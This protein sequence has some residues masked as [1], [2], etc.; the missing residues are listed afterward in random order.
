M[1]GELIFNQYQ[2]FS[3]HNK[4]IS[5]MGGSILSGKNA[6]NL[7]YLQQTCPILIL[8]TLTLILIS[9]QFEDSASDSDLGTPS[10]ERLLSTKSGCPLNRGQIRLISYIGGKKSCP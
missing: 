7:Y 3:Q 2:E 10:G 5:V 6:T 8:S 1:L 4:C 9:L